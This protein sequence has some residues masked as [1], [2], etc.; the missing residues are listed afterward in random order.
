MSDAQVATN[1]H[2]LQKVTQAMTATEQAIQDVA[3]KRLAWDSIHRD[4]A[5]LP[6]E[7]MQSAQQHRTA[8]QKMREA[9]EQQVKLY[10]E[11][12]KG[13]S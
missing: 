8:E 6:E 2:N 10:M 11:I 1:A 12:Y 9:I 3:I 5:S 7:V 4:F 13:Q